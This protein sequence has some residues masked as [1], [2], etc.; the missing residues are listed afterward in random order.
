M[1]TRPL[2]PAPAALRLDR[3][4]LSPHTITVV[5]AARPATARCPV[6]GTRSGRVHARYTR[7]LTDLPGHG[8]R[9]RRTAPVRTFRGDV[10]RCRC[11]LFCARLPVPTAPSGRHPYRAEAALA[12]IG[13]ALGGR[14]GARLAQGLGVPAS[15][16]AVLARRRAAVLPAVPTPASSAWM[17]GLFDGASATAPSWSTWSGMRWS[18]SS[19][20]APPRRTAETRAAWRR[21]HPGVLITFESRSS[22]AIAAARTR[23]GCGKAP[24]RPFRS[25]TAATGCATWVRPS[26]GPATAITPSS[27]PRRR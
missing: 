13:F 9:V 16:T 7:H 4:V 25:R 6:Y 22:V 26:N 12:A 20:R 1:D 5:A 3:L 15:A 18:I 14:P 19:P 21:A 2:C 8:R 11:Q 17:T 27:A 23:R 10:P 24:R